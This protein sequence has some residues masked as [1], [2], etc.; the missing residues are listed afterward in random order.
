MQ[1][2]CIFYKL[3]WGGLIMKKRVACLLLAV[4]FVFANIAFAFANST[5]TVKAGDVLWKIAQE[6]NSTWQK[7]AEVNQL[8]NPNLIYQ[9]QLLELG[10]VGVAVPTTSAVY[11][12]GTY[13]GEA[14]GKNGVIKVSVTV[15]DNSITAVKVIENTETKGIADPAIAQITKRIVESQSIKVDVVS[16][17]TVTCEAII[18]AVKEAITKAKGEL[19]N[20]GKISFVPGTYKGK[21]TGFGGAVELSVTFSEKAITDIKLI[22]SK[23][24]EHV[25]TPAFDI[26]FDEIV[27]HTSTGVDVVSGATY[28]SNAILTAVE[29]AAKQSGC[30]LSA[31]RVGVKPYN[32][33]PS[34]KIVDTYDVVIVGAGGAGLAAAAEAAQNGATVLIIEKQAAAGGNTLVA[35][36]SFQNVMKCLVWDESNPEST[37]G[38]YDPTGET[39]KKAKSD[40]GRIATL[41]TI[42]NWSEKNFDGKVTDSSKINNVEDYDLP[43]RGVHAEYLETLKTLK[44]QIAAYLAWA[45]KKIAAG[46][47][48]TDLTLFSTVELHIFQTYYGGLRLNNDKSEWIYGDYNLVSQICSEIEA[49]K[50]WMMDQGALFQ[51]ATSAG[52][53]I[54]CLWQRIN[55]FDGGMVNGKKEEGKWGTYFAVPINTVLSANKK[56]QIMYRTTATELIADSKG[57]I[58]GVKAS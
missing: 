11:K 22:S 46:A 4:V 40:Q 1:P 50:E 9:G 52:T 12:A 43:L 10:E 34:K 31:L 47:K 35:G 5:Y 7:L 54:G 3:I 55:R 28:T 49:T 36:C 44:K 58:T 51:N 23:E 53:L 20:V 2:Y 27:S 56:N 57:K 48:E 21:G 37:T 16:G 29:D 39:F 15:N 13:Q 25:G 33:T 38:V 14:R 32:L 8:K 26:M 41:N 17:A 18:A 42:L 6:N 19:V 45:D 30:E 24:T